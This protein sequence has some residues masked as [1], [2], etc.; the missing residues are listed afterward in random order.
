MKAAPI[1]LYSDYC[2][3]FELIREFSKRNGACAP[4]AALFLPET[5][6]LNKNMLSI[7]NFLSV[8]P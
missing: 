1:N 5:L 2:G 4:Q 6:F 8:N 7:A 3:V